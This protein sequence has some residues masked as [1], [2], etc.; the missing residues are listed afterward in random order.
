MYDVTTR[1]VLQPV[2]DF[3][4]AAARNVMQ[5]HL[6][7]NADGDILVFM[8]GTYSPLTAP[9]IAHLQV[10]KRLKHA[11]TSYVGRRTS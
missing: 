10:P 5:I 8:P 11:A 2:D 4:E 1:H 9:D 6:R 7:P 3:I